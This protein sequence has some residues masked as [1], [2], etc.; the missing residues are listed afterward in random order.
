VDQDLDYTS[1]DEDF[2]I[3]AGQVVM[4]I[5]QVSAPQTSSSKLRRNKTLRLKGLIGSQEVLILL[6]LGSA[7][8]FISQ[9][10]AK[11]VTQQ[12]VPCEPIQ[13]TSADG[14]LMLSDTLIPQMQWH[15]Q[16]HTFVHD[17]RVL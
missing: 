6:D 10:L 17:I 15:V 7:R 9:E 2:E 5:K 13:F 1:S 4:A 16:G 3:Q 8:S 14:N 12:P 11:T